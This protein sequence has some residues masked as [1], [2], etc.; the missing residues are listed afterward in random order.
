MNTWRNRSAFTIIEIIVVIVILGVMLSIVA[1]M[2]SSGGDVSRVRTAARGVTQTSRYARTM[3]VLHQKAI[4]LTFST[5]GKLSVALEGGEGGGESIV[6]AKAFANTNVVGEAEAARTA[7]AEDSG[8]SGGGAYVMADVNT[9]K[10]YEQVCFEFL[11]YTDTAD[12]KRYS[13]LLSPSKSAGVSSDE[14]YGATEDEDN[15]R[16][17]SVRYKSNGTCRPYKV[18]VSGGGDNAFSLTVA[19]DML[20]AAK[21]EEDEK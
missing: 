20:G 17:V 9:A 2:V 13:H 11:G 5:D 12:A 1:P 7:G 3:A 16:T 8:G 21:V 14:D 15:V 19:V 10:H 4:E 6:S 18:K